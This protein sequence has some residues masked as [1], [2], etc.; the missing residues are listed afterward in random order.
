MTTEN[1]TRFIA[2]A[3]PIDMDRIFGFGAFVVLSCSECHA[4]FLWLPRGPRFCPN[5]GRRNSEA[6]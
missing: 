6:K 4:M 5:C 2:E 1:V 3:P